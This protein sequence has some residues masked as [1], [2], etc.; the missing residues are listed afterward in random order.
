M[1][2]FLS[3]FLEASVDE[4]ATVTINPIQYR[5]TDFDITF[6]V[7]AP[8]TDAQ[9]YSFQ[10]TMKFTFGKVRY[11]VV[12]VLDHTPE[13]TKVSKGVTDY[14]NQHSVDLRQ[15]IPSW[16][17]IIT[18][19]RALIA[20]TRSSDLSVDTFYDFVF[21]KTHVFAPEL[22]SY[23]FPVDPF[24][25]TMFHD[26]FKKFFFK[27]QVLFASRMN[28]TKRRVFKPILHKIDE[29]NS[30][31]KEYIGH[32]CTLAWDLETVGLDMFDS[33][34]PVI[35]MT[36]SFDGK[37]GY[38]LPFD[39]IDISIL[40]DF[41]KGKKGIGSNLKFD[42]K[43]LVLKGVD[44][45]NLVIVGDTVHLGH[46][47]NEMRPNGLKPTTWIYTDLGGYE[48]EL[49]EYKRKYPKVKKDYSLIPPSILFEYATI[50]PIASYRV[51]EA[52]IEQI[53]W[54]DKEFP[55]PDGS[56][57]S[58]ERYY[59]EIIIPSL[60][61]F[62]DIE[63][64]G[65]R[66]DIEKLRTL[67]KELDQSI[68]EK[69]KEIE[70]AL[71]IEGREINI[72]SNEQLGILLES[73]GWESVERAKK[74]HY[75]TNTDILSSWA[76]MGH[77]EAKLILEYRELGTLMKT[78]VGREFEKT[79]FFQYIKAD[80][81]VHPTFK[82]AM[83]SSLRSKCENPN[84]QNIPKHSSGYAKKI[85]EFFIPDNIEQ[86]YIGESDGAGLQL[87]LEA[88]LTKDPAM[89]TVFTELGG[90]MHSMT[91]QEI[92]MPEISLEEFI[93]L[94][95]TDEKVKDY[96]FKSKGVNFS[97]IFNTT[98]FSFSKQ[99]LEPEWDIET[100][101]EYIEKND[102]WDQY[103]F[104]QSKMNTMTK[105][106]V[107]ADKF[108][109]YW[110]VADSIKKKF[111]NKYAGVADHIENII[112]FAHKNGYVR[113][114]FGPIRRLPELLY[115]GEDDRASHIKNLENITTNS[116][117]QTMEATHV[118]RTINYTIDKIKKHGY[119]SRLV[120]MVHDSIVSFKHHDEY[121]QVSQWEKEAFEKMIPENNGIPLE[122][123]VE[124]G[125]PLKGEYWGF[126][127]EIDVPKILKKRRVLSPV[128]SK[129]AQEKK[130]KLRTVS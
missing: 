66:I 62:V 86:F 125:D 9:L 124:I 65:M 118:Y 97:L 35:C 22:K 13:P 55:L 95:K 77:E 112:K 72:D 78:F 96:R 63:L 70:K 102:L 82:V 100:A 44:R 23:V 39:K 3:E 99:S 40:S 33:S 105:D 107:Y 117:I 123:E 18:F 42:I 106:K 83:T 92:F 26:T 52:M 69:R 56:T 21:N 54:I 1:S 60:N 68:I 90:D 53:R 80:G 48:N 75:K 45:D 114:P 130:R 110:T 36:L 43:W 15:Y 115:V 127:N 49:D 121:I 93:S 34:A 109:H 10:K 122:L 101:I 113:C 57:W 111:M 94:K 61:S 5:D 6:L 98:A 85:R 8:L 108:A 2:D 16:S 91:G 64:E 17:K 89:K 88:Q 104:F 11:Q 50:D 14:Y 126:G 81:K 67:S 129:N 76:K 27:K 46:L 103:E 38:Y 20:I 79:G 120:G 87:R 24:E 47:L 119:K 25:I 71:G 51:H 116:P 84:M 31:L 28:V 41:F 7:E 12:S 128:V 29:P 73:L 30:F 4:Q 32:D 58:L 19:G 37:E 74:G 59:Y